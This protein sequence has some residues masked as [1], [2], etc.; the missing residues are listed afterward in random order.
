MLRAMNDLEKRTGHQ[1]RL[2]L[3]GHNREDT[4]GSSDI[5]SGSGWDEVRPDTAQRRDGT[6]P[7]PVGL[8]LHELPRVDRQDAHHQRA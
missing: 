1:V 2:S 5:H 6:L 4:L 7:Y 8:C 3:E